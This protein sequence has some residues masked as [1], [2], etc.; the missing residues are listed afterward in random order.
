MPAPSVG[1]SPRPSEKPIEV[2]RIRVVEDTAELA[3]LTKYHLEQEGHEVVTTTA[4][5]ERLLRPEPWQDVDV[6]IVDLMLPGVRGEEILG[7]LCEHAPE[8]RRIAFTASVVHAADVMGLAH[9]TLI[10]PASKDD[11]FDAVEGRA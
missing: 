9:R 4:E 2:A 7:W 5:F 3:F 1:K 6:A 11:L 10:K 8:I